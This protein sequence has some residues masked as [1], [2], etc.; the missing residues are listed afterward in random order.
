MLSTFIKRLCCIDF[1]GKRE[2]RVSNARADM[3]SRNV[4]RHDDLKDKVEL[5]KIKDHFIF[6]VESTGA[7]RSHEV[8]V[9]ACRVLQDKAANLLDQ[10]IAEYDKWKPTIL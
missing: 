5:S 4:L 6:S 8:V 9:E 10:F 7:M 1:A 2:A 3:C